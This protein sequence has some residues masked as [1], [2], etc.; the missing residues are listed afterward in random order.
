MPF[1]DVRCV[2]SALVKEKL[3]VYLN[4]DEVKSFNEEFENSSL[5]EQQV[6]VE[7]RYLDRK[8]IEVLEVINVT[9]IDVEEID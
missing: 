4:N 6:M 2:Y 7:N 9:S 5:E 3:L 1:Y 8:G